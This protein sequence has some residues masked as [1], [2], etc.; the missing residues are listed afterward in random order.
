MIKLSRELKVTSIIVT[1][2]LQTVYRTAHRIVMLHEGKIIETGSP[3]ATKSSANP[4]VRKF[5]TGGL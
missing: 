4:V 1:H 5:I 3:E 2:V